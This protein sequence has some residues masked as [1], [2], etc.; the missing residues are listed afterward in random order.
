MKVIYTDM[1]KKLFVKDEDK[2]FHSKFGVITKEQL[3]SKNEKTNTG[4][5]VSIIDA[6]FI[7]KF[8]K[9]KRG[10]QII[11]LKDI[12]AIIAFTGISKESIVIDAGSGSGALACALANIVKKVYTYDNRPEHIKTVQENIKF[13]DLKNIEVKEHDVFTGFPKKD[14]DLITLDL[15]EPWLCIEHAYNSLKSGGFL[16]SY[17]PNIGQV[18]EFINRNEKF[19]LVKIIELI[20]RPWVVKGQVARPDFAPFG[21]TGFIIFM[22]KIN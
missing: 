12:G 7:D 22:R 20:E 10:A 14:A 11:N 21:H 4:V 9:I 15:K 6:C 5:E 17:S 8:R 2:D 19:L 1:G 3:K 13:L 18:Q 16:V